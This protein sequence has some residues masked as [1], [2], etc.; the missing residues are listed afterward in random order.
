MNEMNASENAGSSWSSRS[1]ASFSITRTVADV[2]VVA[3][4]IRTGWPVSAPSPKKSPGPSMATTASFPLR[5]R[6]E[7][8][9]LPV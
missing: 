5:D 8:L 1:I 4:P 7:I 9:T 6:T 2:V 3:V